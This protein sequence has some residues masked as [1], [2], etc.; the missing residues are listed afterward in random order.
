[1]TTRDLSH[2]A[3]LGGR[4][5]LY[6]PRTGYRAGVD[7]VLLAAS[8]EAR[9]GQTVLELGCGV[10]AAILCLGARVPGLRLTGLEVQAEYA[11]LA[12]RNAE[13]NDIDLE[14]VTGDLAAMPAEIAQRRFDHVIANPPYF[15]R[16]AGKAAHDPGRETA[17]G[18]VT[19]LAAWL[20]AASRRTA[21]GG[22]V[23]IIHRIERLPDLLTHAAAH[24]GSLQV[25]PLTPRNGRAATR[26]LMCGRKGGR[27]AFR[28]HAPWVLHAGDSHDGDRENY[29]EHTARI[30]RHGAALPIGA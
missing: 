6:Q 20:Q 3:F 4:L 29:T 9:P 10:G 17:L 27:G 13:E 11:A 19:P 7:P 24:L 22:Y 28:L 1:M 30:L 21:P 8:V 2:D 26:V 5:H 12:Q 16:S 23:H 15:D 14:V 18:E 25:L